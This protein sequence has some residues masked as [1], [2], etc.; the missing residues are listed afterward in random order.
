MRPIFQVRWRIH[1]RGGCPHYEGQVDPTPEV[2][3]RSVPEASLSTQR[4]TKKLQDGIQERAGNVVL[5]PLHCI[6]CCQKTSGI[7]FHAHDQVLDTP[8]SR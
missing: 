8:N 2:V 4:G 5:L 6:H 7:Q 3:H 1:I